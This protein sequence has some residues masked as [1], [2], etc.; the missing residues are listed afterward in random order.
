M[1]PFIRSVAETLYRELAWRTDVV[2]R[3]SLNGPASS[4]FNFRPSPPRS[5]SGRPW[6]PGNRRVRANA[7]LAI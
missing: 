7:K 2:G 1:T 5:S 4:G 6:R 3:R